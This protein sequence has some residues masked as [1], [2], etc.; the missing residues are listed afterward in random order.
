VVSKENVDK[1]LDMYYEQR[2]W[3][4]NG[5]PTREKLDELDLDFVTV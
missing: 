5:I 4:Q 1:L 3:D 2:G